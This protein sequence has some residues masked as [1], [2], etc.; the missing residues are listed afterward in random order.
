[1]PS[2]F[3]YFLIGIFFEYLLGF[4]LSLIGYGILARQWEGYY[5]H[6]IL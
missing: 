6:K 5:G 2:I 1:M 3:D 4:L